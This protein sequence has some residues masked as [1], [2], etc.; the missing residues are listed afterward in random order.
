MVGAASYYLLPSLGPIYADPGT[1]AS[2]PISEVTHL[3]GILLDQRIE[4]LRD[5]ATAT[6]QSIA[7]FASLHISISL[8]AAV[9][10]HLLG[11]GRRL[12]VGLWI[13]FG[14]TCL[15]TIHLGWHYVVDDFGGLAVAACR[16]PWPV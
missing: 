3:Q 15:A 1:F 6:P 11:L 5:P 9:A 8:T 10:A 2:L 7:A 16:S 13:W 4:F 14:V 12:K